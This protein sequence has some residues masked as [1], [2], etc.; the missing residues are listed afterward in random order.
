VV[1]AAALRRGPRALTPWH[2][3]ER[4]FSYLAEVQPVLDR[5][6]VKCHDYG[7]PAAR[8][9]NFA[10]DRDLVFNTPTTN[11]GARN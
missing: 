10:H 4:A 6:C 3:P 11:F 8:K 1:P 5:Y 7:Q 2:G 9:V